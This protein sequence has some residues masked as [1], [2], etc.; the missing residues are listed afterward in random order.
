MLQTLG[1]SE[2]TLDRWRARYGGMTCE[3]ARELGG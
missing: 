1:F 2:P 3:E